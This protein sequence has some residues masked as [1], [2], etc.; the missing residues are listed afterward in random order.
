MNH[1]VG[2]RYFDSAIPEPN[3]RSDGSASDPAAG[4]EIVLVTSTPFPAGPSA[5]GPPLT[6]RGSTTRPIFTI[7]SIERQRDQWR[8]LITARIPMTAA[9][10]DLS[11]FALWRNG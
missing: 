3:S 1:P 5:T 4:S 10:V 11:D 6:H 9:D 8:R 7:L 2:K